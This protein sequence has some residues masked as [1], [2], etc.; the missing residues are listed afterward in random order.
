MLNL[1]RGIYGAGMARAI[2][3]TSIPP[4][5]WVGQIVG[6][7][8]SRRCAGFV[9]RGEIFASARRERAEPLHGAAGEWRLEQLLRDERARAG[10]EARPRPGACADVPEPLDR[11]RVPG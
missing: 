6:R 2:V 8:S 9:E 10:A 5:S 11:R 7:D 3:P 1:M 4:P